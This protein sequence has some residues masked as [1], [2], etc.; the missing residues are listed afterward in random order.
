MRWARAGGEDFGSG[1]RTRRLRESCQ[2]AARRRPGLPAE[3]F[4]PEVRDTSLGWPS[5]VLLRPVPREEI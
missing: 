2:Q 4:W 5:F 3:E 1:A